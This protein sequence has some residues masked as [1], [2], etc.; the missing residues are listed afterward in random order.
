M[1][2]IKRR[3]TEKFYLPMFL[4][5]KKC[6]GCNRRL[7]INSEYYPLNIFPNIRIFFYTKQILFMGFISNH[8]LNVKYQG[9]LFLKR[10][11]E[12]ITCISSPFSL[13]VEDSLIRYLNS[14]KK[15]KIITERYWLKIANNYRKPV[16]YLGGSPIPGFMF[17]MNK[18]PCKLA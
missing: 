15:L 2:I 9:D 11:D 6:Y 13:K 12:P 5:V 17:A 18:S 8:S 7:L 10:G 16:F 1:V 3:I 4:R 14:T